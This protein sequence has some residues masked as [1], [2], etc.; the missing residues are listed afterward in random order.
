MKIPLA[1]HP[2]RLQKGQEIIE[3]AFVALL[4]AP[5]FLGMFVIGMNLIMSIQANNMVRNLGDLYIHGADFST[6]PF[7]QLA[8]RMGTGLNLQVPSFSGNLQNN[9]AASGDGIIWI[10]QVMYV[11]ATTDPNCVAAGN[12]N[13]TNHDSF[14]FMQRVVFGNSTLTG[15]HGSSMGDPSGATLSSQGSVSN[16]ITDVKAK[17]PAAGQSAMV[18]LWQTT[19]NG[20]APLADGQVFYAAEGFFQTPSLSLG[21]NVSQGVSVRS[22]F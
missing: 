14:V 7:Q 12:G 3:F 11:G 1:G 4:F 13:C 15:Q 6:Y 17:L 5:M 9:T 16:P 20:Q 8:Q 2:H 10:T 21:N 22:F 19:A 18:A